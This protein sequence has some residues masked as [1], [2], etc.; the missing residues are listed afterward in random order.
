[1]TAA[2][3]GLSAAKRYHFRAVATSAAGT[4]VGADS[5]F[6]TQPVLMAPRAVRAHVSPRHDHLAPYRF[7][8]S[9]NVLRPVGMAAA[10]GCRG[11][12][13][14]QVKHG[15]LI[16]SSLRPAVRRDC[17]FRASVSYSSRRLR[18]SG[19]LKFVAR[20]LGNAALLG[21]SAPTVSAR[22]G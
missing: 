3:S 9:G 13:S 19:Q 4:T 20:F 22:Y 7:T 5:S 2:L 12:V 18:R 17:T 6:V 15:G 21:R 1:V 16:I 11:I 14:V 8:I 10:A